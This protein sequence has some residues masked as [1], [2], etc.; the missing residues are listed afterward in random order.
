MNLPHWPDPNGVWN[1][2]LGLDRVL[3]LLARLGNPHLKLPPMVHIAGTNGKGSTLAFLKAMLE[4]AGHRVHRYTSPHLVHFNERI[5]LAGKPIPDDILYDA[6]ER[7]RIAAGDDIPVTFFEGTTVA[8]FLAFHEHPADVLL[9]ETGMGGRLDATNVV[10]N[11]ICTIITPIGYDHMEFLGDTL[12]KIAAEKAGILKP[13]VP[14][15]LAAQSPDAMAVFIETARRLNAPLLQESLDWHPVAE[16]IPLGLHGAH[17]RQNA[18]AALAA[19]RHIPLNVTEAQQHAGLQHASWPGRL[20]LLQD[21]IWLDGSHNEAGAQVLAREIQQWMQKPTLILGMLAN[22]DA[23][24]FIS[25]LAPHIHSLYTIPIPD[26]LKSFPAQVLADIA[27][28]HHPFVTPCENL[29]M[30]LNVARKATPTPLL[31]TGS[32]YLA[33][34]VLAH[35][36]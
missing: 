19:L 2:D 30:A 20:Q 36:L 27:A 26:E 12:A 1:I 18:G 34:A 14:C 5:E 8:A 21:N 31:I 25:I 3:A 16:D 35:G 4:A 6:L 13:G 23:N 10:P 32:L 17:Q 7:C 11:P 28:A 15:V 33:G 9:L 29:A 22:K 24:A